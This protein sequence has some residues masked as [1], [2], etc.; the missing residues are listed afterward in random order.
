MR[1]GPRDRDDLRPLY[2]QLAQKYRL[3]IYSG[4]ADGC[5]PYVG[6]QEWTEQLG[7]EQIEAWRPWLAGTAANASKRDVTAGYVTTYSAGPQHNFTFLT[8]KGAGHVS[9]Q[10][11]SLSMPARALAR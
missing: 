5:V 2:K 3:L 6:T 4:D 11:L 7:F 10:W 9:D 8:I 1:Y